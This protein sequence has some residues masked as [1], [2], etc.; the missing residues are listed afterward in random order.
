MSSVE[1]L[2]SGAASK[3]KSSQP[4]QLRHIIGDQ[5]SPQ[6]STDT[7]SPELEAKEADT[8]S[9]DSDSAEENSCETTEST[10]AQEQEKSPAL[11]AESESE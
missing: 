5:Q 1:T 7:A 9:E 3:A 8:E 10:P 2:N 4:K 11:D 6:S